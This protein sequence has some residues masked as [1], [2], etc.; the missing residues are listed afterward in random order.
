[1]ASISIQQ[2][3]GYFLR[4][5]SK[6]KRCSG[7]GGLESKKNDRHWPFG[8]F[9][10]LVGRKTTTPRLSEGKGKG[11]GSHAHSSRGEEGSGS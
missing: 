2:K 8:R 9:D 11:K 4:K 5:N 6:A 10:R 1:M 7:K 3:G